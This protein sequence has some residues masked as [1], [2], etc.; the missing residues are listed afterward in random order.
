MAGTL[1]EEQCTARVHALQV[2]MDEKDALI[3]AQKEELDALRSGLRHRQLDE[4]QQGSEVPATCRPQVE[5][6]A[7]GVIRIYQGGA[8]NVGG[9]PDMT[10]EAD[11]A[12]APP[13][14]ETSP[15]PPPPPCTP[16]P[17]PPV[18]PPP[19][20]PLPTPPPVPPVTPPTSPPL[21]AGSKIVFLSSRDFGGGQFGGLA[22]AHAQCSL[23][24]GNAGLSGSFKAWL[25]TT[26]TG[27][28]NFMTRAS[29][30]YYRPDGVLVANNWADLTDGSLANP[31]VV[32][33]TGQLRSGSITMT[34]KTT[35]N[36][37]PPASQCVSW[38]CTCNGWA[39]T[40][41]NDEQTGV[42]N[43][44]SVSSTWTEWSFVNLCARPSSDGYP[45]YCF[46]Q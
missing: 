21:P 12:S 44:L 2:L 18:T 19:L 6:H 24:A 4:V 37:Y 15:P 38:D 22:G 35:A 23:M 9:R 16:P 11:V 34:G 32:T 7:G 29:A 25:S 41:H 42:G 5:V 39:R 20:L 31:I 27:P 43:C 26:N 33:E 28:A 30:A 3:N 8:L 13:P 17:S 45:I 14:P 46:E 10:N 1:E 40:S 36:G